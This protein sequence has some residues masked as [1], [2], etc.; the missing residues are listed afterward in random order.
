MMRANLTGIMKESKTG[1][2]VYYAIPCD[3]ITNNEPDFE[4][5]R[6]AIFEFNYRKPP[7]RSGCDLS[8]ESY[9][10]TITN[11]L[12][13]HNTYVADEIMKFFAGK[14][15]NSGYSFIK[16]PGKYSYLTEDRFIYKM[17]ME[18][19]KANHMFDSFVF[20]EDETTINDMDMKIIKGLLTPVITYTD[21]LSFYLVPT[22]KEFDGDVLN[23]VE[24]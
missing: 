18:Y 7:K 8:I 13:P 9:K 14:V 11:A 20:P 21:K 24:V 5:R 10:Q 2:S 17:I 15:L 6:C 12:L 19:E 22:Y 3:V 1:I 16:I 4:N 23:V